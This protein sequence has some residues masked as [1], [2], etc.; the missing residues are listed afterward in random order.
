[1]G[2]SGGAGV[3]VAHHKGPSVPAAHAT[4]YAACLR[5]CVHFNEHQCNHLE[6]VD[7]HVCTSAPSLFNPPF[8]HRTPP[9]NGHPPRPAPS[10]QVVIFPKTPEHLKTP[11]AE[12]AFNPNGLAQRTISLLKDKFP[13]LEARQGGRACR[14]PA[15]LDLAAPRRAHRLGLAS[16]PLA[17]QRSTRA[18]LRKA[19]GSVALVAPSRRSFVSRQP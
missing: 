17:C 10:L 6:R 2:C 1:M 14:L 13:D 16:A 11:T 12:E 3:A 5:P 7:K 19:R 4:V 9:T 15:V 8:T 18:G